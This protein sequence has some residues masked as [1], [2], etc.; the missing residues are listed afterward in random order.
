MPDVAAGVP[1]PHVDNDTEPIEL[2][3]AV[4]PLADVTMAISQVL[5]SNTGGA[6]PGPGGPGTGGG[7]VRLGKSAAPAPAVES[8]PADEPTNGVDMPTNGVDLDG[9]QVID[10]RAGMAD[11]SAPDDAPTMDTS[12]TNPGQRA[13]EPTDAP[14]ASRPETAGR[15]TTTV[16]DQ[17]LEKIIGIVVERVDGVHCLGGDGASIERDGDT[18]MIT[19]AIVVEYGSSVF[20]VAENVRVGVIEGIQA[21]LGV[22]V[23]AVD[24]VI[25]D[26]YVP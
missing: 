20:G 5:A 24:I 4:L 11:A 1:T 6:G 9:T 21:M 10:L 26:V 17:F 25:A 7:P 19:I 13:P 2:P 16:P 23:V 15:G 14:P 22:E 8:Y 12:A 3:T 18:A